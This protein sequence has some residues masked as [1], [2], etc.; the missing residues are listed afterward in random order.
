MNILYAVT[1]FLSFT[2][3][4]KPANKTKKLPPEK[5]P[6]LV[7]FWDFQKQENGTISLQSR[8]ASNYLLK[9]MNGKIDG[10][11]EGIFGPSSLRILRGQ[12]LMIPRKECPELDIHG[13]EE[14]SMVAW[15]KRIGDNN[16]QYIAGMWNERDA[17]RQYGLFTCA[18]KQTDQRTLERTNARNQTHG[19]VSDVGGA[20]T[21]RPYC[22]SY[23]SGLQKIEKEQWYMLA[24]TYDHQQLRV[25]VN[26]VLDYQENY[27]PFNWDKPI[28]SGG[29]DGSDF[30]V[31]QRA[32]PQWPGY[33]QSP[34]PPQHEGF[35]G[36]LGGLAVY[37]RA[38][39][40]AEINK[41]YKKTSKQ[42]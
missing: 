20:T 18:H 31:A 27:N 38:L 13:K 19:Y 12:W 40:A 24:F 21:D 8:G 32:L 42:K 17:Q 23:A 29:N 1:V 25:Y 6:N 4:G 30:T 15:I 9:E 37:K 11:T 35:D 41:L 39:T 28:F 7:T 33:P 14:I 26:G 16:W 5:I 10:A 36:L 22:Y 34:E 3:S 2:L